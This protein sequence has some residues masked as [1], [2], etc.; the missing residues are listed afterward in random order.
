MRAF[1][2]VLGIDATARVAIV[3]AGATWADI[4]AA[5]NPHGLAV[6]VQ[7]SSNIFTIGGS[8]AVN[9]HGRD[10]RYGC[11]VDTVRSLAL[12]LADGTVVRATRTENPDLFAS[13]LGGYGLT[14][15]VLSAEVALVEDCWLD[16]RIVALSMEAYVDSLNARMTGNTGTSAIQLHFGR[17]SIRSSDFLDRVLTVDYRGT[18]SYSGDRPERLS[19]ES[20]VGI[21]RAMMSLSRSGE[22]GKAVRWYLQESIAERPGSR[23]LVSRNNAMRPEVRFLDYRSARDTDILQEYFVPV[24]RLVVFMQGLKTVARNRINLLSVTLRIVRKDT[25]TALAYARGDLIAVVVYANVGRDV[26]SQREASAWTQELVALSLSLEG[27][28]YLPYQRW[29][30]KEQFDACYPRSA[31]FRAI[32]KTWDPHGMF[33]NRWSQAYLGL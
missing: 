25:T 16:R 29:P 21:N 15:V 30:T 33:S 3:E 18:E 19:D 11:L 5:A 6:A 26:A 22:T 31:E 12:M 14:G 7:Q 1:N 17:P 2:R 20:R 4:Q 23:M 10:P 27:V 9:C 28:Y 32:K 24:D 13:T 8:I